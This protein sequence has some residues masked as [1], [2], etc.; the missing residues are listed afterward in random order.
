MRQ[1]KRFK[2]AAAPISLGLVLLLAGCTQQELNGFMPGNPNSGEPSVTN[3]SDTIATFWTNSWIILMAIGILV[4]VLIIWASVVYRRR[5]GEQGLPTQ[6]RYHMP[7][8]ILFTVIPVILVAG[9]FAFTAREQAKVEENFTAETVDVHV[10]VYGKQWAWDFNYL[11]T[12][13]NDYDAGVYYEGVQASPAPGATNGEIDE[14]S[15]PVLYLPVGANVL[16]DLKSRDVSHSFWV[17]DFL[18][19]E[20]TIPG[21]TNQMSIV[22]EREG[23][24]M[25]K[26]AE[27]C[28]EY[29]SMMLFQVKVV[30]QAEYNDYIAS[31]RAEGNE[32]QLGDDF[33]RNT[34]L[35]GTDI[36]DFARDEHADSN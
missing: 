17:I 34:N 33:N 18:Y 11:P 10:E 31:L 21:Q 36:P 30:S 26:C 2:W 9:F 16:I 15:L 8:E 27:L 13:N 12:N 20:D 25:G 7:I 14:A 1:G 28:G 22:P 24:Y 29:H 23:T 6:L 3:H 4:W 35:Q 5:K 32:G 19:K